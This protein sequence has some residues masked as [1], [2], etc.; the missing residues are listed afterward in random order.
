MRLFLA[1]AETGSVSAA[2]QRVHVTQPTASMQLREMADQVGLP[3][4]EWVSRRVRLTPAGEALAATA[5]AMADHWD[6]FEQEIAALKGL[7]QGRL[8]VAVVS[9]AKYLVPRL[10]GEFCAQHPDI[11][12]ALEVL[13]RDGVVA[14]LRENRDDL[15]VMSTPPK[16]MELVDDVFM[17]NPLVLVAPS[18]HPL[19]HAQAVRLGDL[20]SERFLLREPG[21][22]TR[23]ACEERFRALAF[24]PTRRLELGS[25]EAICEAVAGGLGV[26]VVSIHALQARLGGGLCILAVEGFPIPSQW[27]VVSRRGK[28]LSPIARVFREHLMRAGE[29]G[30]VRR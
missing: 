18:H 17:P 12:I 2:A 25:T 15:Y 30:G 7:T 29:R 24:E 19:A 23:M 13:N 14:R 3:L 6:A 27:H 4:F 10:L 20:A 1:L 26:A 11:E 16:D 28:P 8:R 9:T 5:R 21:S 22:G